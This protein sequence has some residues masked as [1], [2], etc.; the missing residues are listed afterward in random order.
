MLA[1]EMIISHIISTQV[2]AHPPIGVLL[3]NKPFSSLKYCDISVW[4]ANTLKIAD[5]L[6]CGRQLPGRAH[7]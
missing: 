2:V 4:A 7:Q 3:R 5:D 1:G 6:R